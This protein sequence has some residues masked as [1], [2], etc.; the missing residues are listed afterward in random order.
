VVGGLLPR[1]A[2][3]AVW[4]SGCLAVWL[5]GCLAVWLSGLLPV[6]PFMAASSGD[7]VRSVILERGL[8]HGRDLADSLD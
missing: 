8:S 3:L 5:S 7:A 4:L 1:R 6:C 2:C